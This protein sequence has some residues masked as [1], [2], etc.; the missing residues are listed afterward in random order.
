MP[1]PSLGGAAWEGH[2]VRRLGGHPPSDPG[3]RGPPIRNPHPTA[4]AV[5]PHHGAGARAQPPG[6]AEEQPWRR[7]L[8]GVSETE[9]ERQRERPGEGREGKKDPTH[10]TGER[11]AHSAS[12][13]DPGAGCRAEARRA[14]LLA[15]SGGRNH[16]ADTGDLHGARSISSSE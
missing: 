3:G 5:R 15:P 9:M 8:R 6:R 1:T 12:C 10:C 11:Q 13:E 4:M 2:A 14:P 7:L 16:R